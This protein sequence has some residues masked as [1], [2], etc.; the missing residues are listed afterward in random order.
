M[1]P[2]R[3]TRQHPGAE[4][5]H[6]EGEEVHGLR[7]GAPGPVRC[8]GPMG[9]DEGEQR[10]A[11]APPQQRRRRHAHPSRYSAAGRWDI[12]SLSFHRPQTLGAKTCVRV[13]DVL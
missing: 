1:I 12:I 9:E 2:Y 6:A 3:L 5:D 7:E 4:G 13:E 11:A 8:H 10:G